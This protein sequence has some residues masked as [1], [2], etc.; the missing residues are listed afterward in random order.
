M[1]SKVTQNYAN[2]LHTVDATVTPYLVQTADEEDPS[3][4]CLD[5][6]SVSLYSVTSS[7]TINK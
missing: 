3:P 6:S 2:I 1:R 7:P 5:T 4:Q